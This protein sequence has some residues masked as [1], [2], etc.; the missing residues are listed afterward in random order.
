MNSSNDYLV[1]SRLKKR[2]D[3]GKKAKVPFAITLSPE[4]IYAI[5][6]VVPLGK[7]KYGS[8]FL[9]LAGWLL[10]AI[11]TSG[12]DVESIAMDLKK[13]NVSP[14][15]ISNLTRLLRILQA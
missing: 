11:L 15:L 6:R 4:L 13:T 10:I 1:L 14:F 2:S 12:E 5:G 9:E 8:S 3:K 7:G